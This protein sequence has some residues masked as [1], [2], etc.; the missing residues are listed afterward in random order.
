MSVDLDAHRA[1]VRLR[2]RK[3]PE[4]LVEVDHRSDEQVPVHDRE[5]ERRQAERGEDLFSGAAMVVP[6]G[7]AA[8][9]LDD[10]DPHPHDHDEEEYADKYGGDVEQPVDAVA[11]DRNV[12]W[13]PPA[14]LRL[15]SGVRGA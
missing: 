3:I 14:A 12:A 6:S 8:A 15:R 13:I 5:N 9:M 4:R 1:G 10:G 7:V 11:F 2:L